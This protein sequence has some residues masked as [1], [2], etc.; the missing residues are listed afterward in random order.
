MYF[1]ETSV[2]TK[3]IDELLS[4]DEFRLL[5]TSLVLQPDAGNIIRQSGGIR[6]LRWS[7]SGRGKRGGI[8]IIYYYVKDNEKIF[9][10][11]AYSKNET[12]DLTSKQINILKSIIDED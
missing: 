5:Q 10:L 1:V 2:F 11:Y 4:D 8:R 9:L 7:V 3:R 12:D 6:K